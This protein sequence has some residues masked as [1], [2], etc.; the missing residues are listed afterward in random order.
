MSTKAIGLM[1]V[2]EIFD[3]VD[4]RMS[5]VFRRLASG[6]FD[7]SGRFYTDEELKAGAAT[8]GKLLPADRKTASAA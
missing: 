3:A 4:S 5:E 2:Q 1:T 7:G 8:G 6:E